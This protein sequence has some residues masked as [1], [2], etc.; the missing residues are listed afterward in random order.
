M[1]IP[2]QN[3]D[4]GKGT[5]GVPPLHCI[6]KISIVSVVKRKEKKLWLLFIISIHFCGTTIKLFIW[7]GDERNWSEFSNKKKR[8]GLKPSRSIESD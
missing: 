3:D 8:I 7:L 4:E 5:K 6:I 1:T 2:I